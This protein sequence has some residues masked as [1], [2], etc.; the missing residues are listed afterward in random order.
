MFVSAVSGD[1]NVEAYSSMGRVMALYR[2]VI[3]SSSFIVQSIVSLHRRYRSCWYSDWT[4][5]YI[6]TIQ[7][8]ST[9]RVAIYGTV[10]IGI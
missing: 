6:I 1:H 3:K 5:V 9:V 7:V 2:C 4:I 8:K 10:H